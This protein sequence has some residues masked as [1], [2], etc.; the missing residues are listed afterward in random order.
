[1]RSSSR[2]S[3]RRG[4]ALWIYIVLI[5]FA[6]VA[7]FAVLL[8]YQNIV[9]RKVEGKQH[10][11]RPIEVDENTIDAATWGKNYPRQYD[12]YRRTVDTERTKHGGSEAFQHLD[13]DPRWRRIFSGYTFAVD[14]R[15]ER[16][17]AYMLHDQ[18][19]TER[20]KSF[21]QP[22]S[23]LHCHAA[24]LPAYIAAGLKA[25]A[26]AGEENREKQ[27]Q[28]GFEEICALPYADARQL[29]SHPVTCIDCHEA[30]TMNLR[31][32]RPAF[33]TGIRALANSS[34]STPH[35]PS[36]ERWR[37]DGRSGD[38]EPNVMASRQE[39]RSLVL[40]QETKDVRWKPEVVILTIAGVNA[41][42]VRA[43]SDAL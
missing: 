32:S 15:E 36:I 19:E 28:K 4:L 6:A 8:L 29:V 25:G 30:S 9:T 7:C 3:E 35:L 42:N 17:H 14:Y 41:K 34:Q 39:L 13:Q 33:I 43:V 21:K 10:A 1:M 27:I 20:V 5:G 11:F 37:S 40:A 23:C 18:D 24:V 22:G 12:S 16:G 38:Y 26:P 31:V 2:F